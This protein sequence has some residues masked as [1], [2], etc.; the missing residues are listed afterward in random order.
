[1][2]DIFQNCKNKLGFISS[3]IKDEIRNF[4]KNP[5][6]ENWTKISFLI[7]GADSRTTLHQAVLVVNPSIQKNNFNQWERIPKVEE[8]YRAILIAG[9][10]D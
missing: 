6:T 2:V 9:N 5:T 10:L 8:V 7:I 3:E 4:L 1:M